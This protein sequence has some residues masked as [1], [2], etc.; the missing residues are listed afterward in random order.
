MRKNNLGFTLVELLISISIIALL[1]VAASISYSKAQKSGRDQKRI[2]DLRAV[3]EA[4]E[5]YYLLNN[6]AYPDGSNFYRSNTSWSIDGQNILQSFPSDPKGDSYVNAGEYYNNVADEDAYCVCALL[7]GNKG[8]SSVW[9][10]CNN[11]SES[12]GDY[13][14]VKNQQ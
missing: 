3:Q 11:L 1:M 12:N 10:N 4:A 2:G 5:Q 9:A 8:N 14:C 7:E 13:F 6:G